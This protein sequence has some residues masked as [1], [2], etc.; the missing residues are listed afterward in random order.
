MASQ[1]AVLIKTDAWWAVKMEES[2][3]CL[4]F[5]DKAKAIKMGLALA[6]KWGG[7]LIIPNEETLRPSLA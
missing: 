2:E 4:F 7:R 6:R 1:N 3:T 5:R